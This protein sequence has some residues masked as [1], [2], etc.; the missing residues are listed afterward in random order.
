M[1][2]TVNIDTDELCCA[3]VSDFGTARLTDITSP[4]GF[5]AAKIDMCHVEGL[6]MKRQPTESH[7]LPPYYSVQSDVFQFGELS[8]H[9][10]HQ[11][12]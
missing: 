7:G 12:C 11:Q 8:V 9:T 4:S 5:P 2:L 10:M 6:Q 1:L 3:K